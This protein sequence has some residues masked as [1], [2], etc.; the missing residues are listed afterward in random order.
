LESFFAVISRQLFINAHGSFHR[1]NRTSLWN[2]FVVT[3]FLF[4]GFGFVG[5]DA[6]MH[7]FVVKTNSF[8]VSPTKTLDGSNL[9]NHAVME[10]AGRKK[11]NINNKK[12]PE[13]ATKA[14]SAIKVDRRHHRFVSGF[15]VGPTEDELPKSN[16]RGD[17]IDSIH[18]ILEIILPR[19][20]F[21]GFP[22]P[23]TFDRNDHS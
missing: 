4:S 13:Y 11:M 8:I 5:R 9:A 16:E 23:F 10:R 15:E 22:I 12:N 7:F 3:L 6:A 19:R 14:A 17:S 18:P 2:K 1:R 20:F 21:L